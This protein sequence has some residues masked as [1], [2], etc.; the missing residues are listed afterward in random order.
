VD[1]DLRHACHMWNMGL[2]V[3]FM[4]FIFSY[5]LKFYL[6]VLDLAFHIVILH[7]FLFLKEF[8]YK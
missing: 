5:L 1:E 6:Y 7:L 3:P 8:L 4:P 2:W